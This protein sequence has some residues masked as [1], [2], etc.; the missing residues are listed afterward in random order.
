[1][2]RLG[3][4]NIEPTQ[5]QIREVFLNRIVQG[6]GLSK[7]SDLVSGIIMP[8]PSAM[9]TAMELLSDGWE[10]H[11]GIGEL[12]GVDLGG[13]TTDVY[14][15]AEGSP[16]NM[17]TVMKGDEVEK[18]FKAMGFDRVFGPGTAPETTIAA[19]YEDFGIEAPKTA[20]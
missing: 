6:K 8:T 9:L 4:L 1:M 15:I 13:A 2:P 5:K 14:S 18:R 16:A 7:A 10:E 20:E 3:E 17:A 11:Q 12:V 19:L